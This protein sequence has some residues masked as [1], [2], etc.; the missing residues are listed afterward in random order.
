M[1]TLPPK[2]PPRNVQRLQ[3]LITQLQKDSGTSVARLNLRVAAMM[4]AGALGR[5]VDDEGEPIF[6]IKGGVAMELRILD[7]ARATKDVDFVLRGV[8]EDLVNHLADA[9]DEDYGHFSFTVKSIETLELR[10]HVRRALIQVSFGGRPFAT[11]KMEV[12]PVEEGAEDFENLPGIDLSKLGIE[13]PDQVPVLALRGQIAQKIHA[14]TEPPLKEG[15][16]NARYW[17]LIDLMILDALAEDAAVPLTSIRQSCVTIFKNRDQHDWP[18]ELVI[19]PSWT[20]DYEK[21]ASAL[22]R[23]VTDVAQAA[24]EVR[25]FIARIDAAG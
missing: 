2:K 15:G 24:R 12:S 11:V 6:V 21:M 3:Q 1:T 19:Y 10:P 9:L 14:V 20:G 25:A 7:E 13:G 5:A 16:E 4:L 23:D 17:D 22:G 8:T 18:P